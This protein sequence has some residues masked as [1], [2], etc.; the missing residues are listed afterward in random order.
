VLPL[1]VEAAE[2]SA[3]VT[4]EA[5]QVRRLDDIYWDV[6]SESDRVFLK[7]D[8]QGA[9]A[10]VLAGAGEALKHVVG[11]QLELSLQPLYEGGATIELVLAELRE[12][13]FAPVWFTPGFKHPAKH[14]LLQ[15]DGLF[16]RT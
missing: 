5:V 13:G 7:V 14:Q 16:F 3:A 15:V 8:A 12:R 9:E 2:S 10:D 11:L 1:S 4:A 6:V